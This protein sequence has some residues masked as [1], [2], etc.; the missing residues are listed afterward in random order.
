MAVLRVCLFGKLHVEYNEQK[1]ESLKGKK[2]QELFCYLLLHRDQAHRREALASLLWSESS[3]AQARKYLRQTIWQILSAISAQPTLT[4][5]HILE[6]NLGWV[7]IN[8]AP[9]LWLDVAVF[10]QAFTLVQGV[11]GQQLNAEQAQALQHAERLY[12]G[13][14]LEGWYQDW[15]LSERERLQNM[16]LAML[17][18]LMDYC[19]A[20]RAYDAGLRYGLRSLHYDRAREHTHRRLM[21]LHYLAGDRTAAL[22]QYVMC[23]KALHDEFDAQPRAST[24]QL[25]QQIRADRLDEPLEAHIVDDTAEASQPLPETMGHL[26]QLRETLIEIQ[27]QVA[28]DISAIE[29]ILG[30]PPTGLALPAAVTTSLLATIQH[31]TDLL[32]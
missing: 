24:V 4:A 3:E 27:R 12:Q 22:R 28:Q 7:Q 19:E 10:E 30:L 2:V 14:L 5:T 20:Q 6:A 23:V 18:K 26:H 21:R 15:C 25:Y 13:D 16:Y 32:M 17:D 11:P 31:I 29:K 8:S 9:E 1:I